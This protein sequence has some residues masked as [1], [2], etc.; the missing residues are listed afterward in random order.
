MS[1]TSMAQHEIVKLAAETA[2]K[3][4]LETVAKEN[5][6]Y[7]KMRYD[8]RLRNTKL[9]LRNYRML[10]EH[11][12][13]SAFDAGEVKEQM[14]EDAI[15]ILDLMWESADL[16]AYVESLKNSV[17]RTRTIMAHIDE[18]L[19][20]YEMYCLKNKKEEERRRFRVTKMFY[21]DE[22]T[23]T[24]EEIAEIEH[25]DKRTVYRDIESAVEKISALIF[26][27]DGLKKD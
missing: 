24:A 1:K 5:K 20:F 18:M 9:L 10:K 4:A 3:M 27:I 7:I 21:I 15:D 2:A 6:N 8:K 23:F 11:I 17:E 25:I 19:G 22:E 13:G 14:R 26:G 16:T 12:A